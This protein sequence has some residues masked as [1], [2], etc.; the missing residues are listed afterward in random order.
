MKSP[1]DKYR[2]QQTPNSKK[3]SSVLNISGSYLNQT[4]LSG[5]KSKEVEDLRR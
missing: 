2:P 3:E 4:N 1:L 5:S